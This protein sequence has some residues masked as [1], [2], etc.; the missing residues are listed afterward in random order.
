MST[1]ADYAAFARAYDARALDKGRGD[2]AIAAL[3]REVT[4]NIDGPRA[5]ALALSDWV[6]KHIRY[7][8]VYIGAGGVVPHPAA[9]VLENRYGDCKDH[10]S[11]LE[12]L[13]A[14]VGIDSTG[15]LIN[16]GNAYRLPTTPTLGVFNH[17]ITYV[18][19]LD[20]YLDST[21]ESIAAGYLPLSDL[22]KPVLLTG[23]GKMAATPSAQGEKSR[24][25]TTFT[26]NKNGH[27]RFTVSLLA[28]GAIAEP[29]RKAVLDATPA[30]R[31][32]FVQRML[33]AMG[34]KGA[35][36]FDAGKVDAGVDEYNMTF[37]GTS[38]DFIDLPGPVALATSYHFWGGMKELAAT[39][40]RE[41]Q[42]SQHFVCPAID[43]EDVTSFN[44]PAG[45]R[46]IALP[47]SLA[48]RDANLLYAASYAATYA[49]KGHKVVI[50]RQLR[51]AHDGPVC[52][53]AEYER[54]RGLLERIRR[55]L[56]SQLIVSAR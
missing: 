20:L 29:Y 25:V 42:R 28:A 13:L 1:F 36:V 51:F 43:A 26:M 49:R 21:A 52:T 35:G 10:A 7:V 11:L 27:G 23:S 44:F 31:A 56:K 18:P 37:T 40:A 34:Q 6:R 46:I 22:G 8:G 39:F 45:V 41:P 53:A 15:A 50:R 24:S 54:M 30:E 3:A 14:A 12:A 38:D 19:S 55:D 4:G 5:K 16:S 2:P 32:Q 9:T 17:V 33:Q 47:K 48:L